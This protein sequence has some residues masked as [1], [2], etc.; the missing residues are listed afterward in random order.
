[1]LHGDLSNCAGET[2]AFRCEDC[3]LKVKDTLLNNIKGK[4][5]SKYSSAKIDP[6]YQRVLE[7]YFRNTNY[8]VDIVINKENYTDKVKHLLDDNLMFSRL[9]IINKDTEISTRLVT[10]DITYY[11]DDDDNRRS[12][13]SNKYAVTLKELRREIGV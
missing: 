8:S 7:H 10:G 3:I 12:V 6:L 2:L 5:T 13:V 9:V 4:F 11:I 1:M